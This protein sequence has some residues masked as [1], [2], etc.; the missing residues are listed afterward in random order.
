[1]RSST[2]FASLALFLF[3]APRSHSQDI[4]AGSRSTRLQAGAGAMYL[5][6]DYAPD[7]N[8]GVA[9]WADLDLRRYLGL[10]VEGRLGGIVSPGDIGENSWLLGPRLIYRRHPV[11]LYAKLMLGRAKIT[12]QLLNQSSTFNVYG[13]G[14]GLEYKVTPKLNIRLADVELQR[15]PDFQPNSLSPLAITVG[16]SYVVR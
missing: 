8:Q 5:K 4:A 14:G 11:A 9:F 7:A 16:M 2:A 3:V 15:W 1:M 13:F 12:N 10:E 6:T